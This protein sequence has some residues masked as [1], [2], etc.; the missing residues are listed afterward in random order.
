MFG[1]LLLVPILPLYPY[2]Y[3][4]LIECHKL[5]AETY[6]DIFSGKDCLLRMLD[7]KKLLFQQMALIV[8][9]TTLD[10]AHKGLFH[11]RHT[12]SGMR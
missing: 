8:F 11:L 5:N 3:L 7:F 2:L 9:H 6:H 10:T 12:A 4:N 1:C